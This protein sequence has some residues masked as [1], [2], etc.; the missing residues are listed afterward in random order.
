MRPFVTR[1]ST[2]SFIFII[3]FFLMFLGS[4]FLI[5]SL[6]E[7]SRIAILLSFLVIVLGISCAFFAF[8]LKWRSVYLFFAALFL[9]AGIF[10]F[11]YTIHIIPFLLSQSWPLLS[12]FAGIAFLPA[13]WHRYGVIKP[14]YIVL[15]VTF[16]VLGIILMIFALKLVSFSLAQFIRNWW[17][18]IVVLTGLILVL[19]SLG[20]K[21]SGEQKKQ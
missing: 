11:L 17:P 16:I 15:S 20:A 4:A 7:V 13:G 8:K 10:L 21:F 9:Q 14:G 12:I 5:E 19:I 1:R 18:L 6:V 2:A 3:G